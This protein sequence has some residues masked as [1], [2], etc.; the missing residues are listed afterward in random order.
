M[1]AFAL[2]REIKDLSSDDRE[3]VLNEVIESLSHDERRALRDELC[4]PESTAK[5]DNLR[6]QSAA[7]QEGTW[8]WALEMMK[9][10]K[11]CSRWFNVDGCFSYAFI[12]DGVLLRSYVSFESE[13]EWYGPTLS[14]LEATDWG[15]SDES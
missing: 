6:P 5:G 7:P 12:E 11:R 3:T 4:P 8:A 13:W 1:D 10:G 15:L 2:I 14:D 9:A